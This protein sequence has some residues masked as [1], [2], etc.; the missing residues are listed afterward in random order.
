MT[1]PIVYEGDLLLCICCSR[2]W[3]GVVIERNYRYV[4]VLWDFFTSEPFFTKYDLRDEYDVQH[5]TSWKEYNWNGK[6]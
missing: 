1:T 6:Q 3:I 5:L 4:R 2:K